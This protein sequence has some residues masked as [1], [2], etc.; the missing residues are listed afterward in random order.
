MNE[1][2]LGSRPQ[3]TDGNTCPQDAC[4]LLRDW[5]TRVQEV[6]V[7][8]HLAGTFTGLGTAFTALPGGTHCAQTGGEIVCCCGNRVAAHAGPTAQPAENKAQDDLELARKAQN[9]EHTLTRLPV[10][11]QSLEFSLL[12]ESAR[13]LLSAALAERVWILMFHGHRVEVHRSSPPAPT[14]RSILV[15]PYLQKQSTKWTE[16]TERVQGRQEGT[17]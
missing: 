17:R 2:P 10:S 14:A 13:A 4:S 7:G 9:V 6:L 11:A 12:L 3:G 16:L 15:A 5:H 1:R 8:C